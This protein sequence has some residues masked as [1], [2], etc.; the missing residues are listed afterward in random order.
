MDT[1]HTC[2]VLTS[3]KLRVKI[4]LDLVQNRSIFA[5]VFPV[6]LLA[7][8]GHSLWLIPAEPARSTFQDLISKFGEEHGAPPF[9]A[10]A[11]LIAA[12]NP[13]GGE[14]EVISKAQS[15]AQEL[16]AIS[17]RVERVACKDL[18]FQSVS[19]AMLMGAFNAEC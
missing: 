4:K 9:E 18:Y 3:R 5:T 2:K 11:T 10:H 16:K 8:T 17:V 6:L 19:P 12:L 1:K 7:N 13:D 15:L 14:Q